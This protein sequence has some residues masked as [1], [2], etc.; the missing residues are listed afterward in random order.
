MAYEK[1]AVAVEKSQGEIRKLLYAHGATNFAFTET[2]VESTR[3]AA[4]DFVLHEQRVRVRV[5]LKDPDHRVI[6]TKAR[7]AKVRTAADIE[8]D[9]FEQEAKRIWRVMF[10]VLKAR[11]VSVEEGVETFEEAFLAHIVDPMTGLTM[12]DA[13]KVAVEAGALKPGG[14]GLMSVPILSLGAGPS[15]DDVVEAEVVG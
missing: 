12:W 6:A 7:A 9:L 10:H 8:R 2:A 1:T 5:A 15:D 3:W 4:I 14:A 11:L 13:V